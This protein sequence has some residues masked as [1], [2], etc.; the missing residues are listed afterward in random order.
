MPSGASVGTTPVR[1]QRIG[2]ASFAAPAVPLNF[3]AFPTAPGGGPA[4][5]PADKGPAGQK[6]EARVAAEIPASAE[7]TPP[8]H[9]SAGVMLATPAPPLNFASF[10]TAPE[11]GPVPSPVEETGGKTAEVVAIQEIDAPKEHAGKE[12]S[13]AATAAAPASSDAD[14]SQASGRETVTGISGVSPST[15][16]GG[17]SSEGAKA[18]ATPA[19]IPQ[20]AMT[21]VDVTAPTMLPPV[22]S[23]STFAKAWADFGGRRDSGGSGR[24]GAELERRF[25]GITIASATLATPTNSDV[26]SVM[27]PSSARLT[28]VEDVSSMSALAAPS[29]ATRTAGVVSGARLFSSKWEA[30]GR[31]QAAVV[32]EGQ[33][34]PGPSGQKGYLSEASSAGGGP[35]KSGTAVE[36]ETVHKVTGDAAFGDK[37]ALPNTT[38]SAKADSGVDPEVSASPGSPE[39]DSPTRQDEKAVD[40][41]EGSIVVKPSAAADEA[42]SSQIANPEPADEAR[43]DASSSNIDVAVGHPVEK[44]NLLS[45]EALAEEGP[46]RFA[47]TEQTGPDKDEKEG[48]VDGKPKQDS[49]EATPAT[50][51][52]IPSASSDVE[53]LAAASCGKDGGDR[54]KAEVDLEP[55]RNEGEERLT[56]GE[57][58][59]NT[60]EKKSKISEHDVDNGAQATSKTAGTTSSVRR[61]EATSASS[62]TAR[63]TATTTMTQVSGVEDTEAQITDPPSAEPTVPSP[64]AAPTNVAGGDAPSPSHPSGVSSAVPAT[65]S[66]AAPNT[67]EKTDSANRSPDSAD[68]TLARPKKTPEKDEKGSAESERPQGNIT[69]AGASAGGGAGSGAEGIRSIILAGPEGAFSIAEA[70]EAHS[71][72][73]LLGASGTFVSVASRRGKLATVA[74]VDL[75][76][77]GA[78]TR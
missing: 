49:K 29:P 57:L 2:A 17:A 8:W 3:A 39:Q 4:L 30:E 18:V 71:K 10:S 31:T 38:D 54:L 14:A 69:G 73:P 55:V 70:A 77:N 51:S 37:L 41:L 25:S 16:G 65:L 22:P 9:K 42:G 12:V 66:A 6:D 32:R 48:P 5:S 74:V 40:A 72:S 64:I 21:A 23:S 52:E 78:T 68:P 67:A 35:L 47:G 56:A 61:A 75:W 11:G 7:N 45:R 59:G 34:V 24:G 20:G 44:G 46:G 26:S 50:A 58:A 28:L 43:T 19:P 27:T 62:R 53:K 60:P 15:G 13:E 33:D 63:N 1:Q 76:N 36:G